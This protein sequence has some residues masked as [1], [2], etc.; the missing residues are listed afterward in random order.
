MS[1]QVFIFEEESSSLEY[2]EIK[3]TVQ[4]KTKILPNMGLSLFHGR[5]AEIPQGRSFSWYF[6]LTQKQEVQEILRE[7]LA[8]ESFGS[9]TGSRDWDKPM[10]CQHLH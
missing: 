7:S 6:W 3:N 1:S 4:L 10:R 9:T 5:S 8:Q 2:L